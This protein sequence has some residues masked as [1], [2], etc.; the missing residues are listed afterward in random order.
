MSCRTATSS[1]SGL[2]FSMPRA[3]GA[4][5]LCIALLTGC[6]AQDGGA[7]AVSSAPSGSSEPPA[8][9]AA[10]SLPT[11]SGTAS[12]GEK[13]LFLPEATNDRFPTVIGLP[14]TNDGSA[15]VPPPK[16]GLPLP[17]S[18]GAQG[19]VDARAA[20]RY[21]VG[22]AQI[23]L[24]VTNNSKS[25][26]LYTHVFDIRRLEDGQVIPLTPRTT[27]LQ[28]DESLILPAGETVTIQVPLDIYEEP[29]PAGTYMAAQL[30]CFTDT[31]GQA[32]ACTGIEASFELFPLF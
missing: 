25:D 4:L 3:F 13:D 18:A 11:S 26:L 24:I 9:S 2:M 17:E 21:P 31:N 20:D 19:S 28:P 10:S 1:C 29:L 14:G 23:E 27:V 22:T 32:L 7:A 15:E 5:L 12:A 30:A 8:S 6:T 16:N